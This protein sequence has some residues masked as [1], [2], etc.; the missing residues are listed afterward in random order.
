MF[1]LPEKITV[2]N[3]TADDGFGGKTW[4][5]SIYNSRHAFKSEQFRDSQGQLTVSK[6]VVY[7]ENTVSIGDRVFIGESTS[8]T[9]VQA[10]EVV[11]G[12]SSVASFTNMKKVWL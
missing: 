5:R 12:L 11:R 2:W 7:T 10:A 4:S 6:A 8:S 1:S 9:P 3:Q